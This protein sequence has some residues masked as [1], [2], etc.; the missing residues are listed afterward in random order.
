MTDI[1]ECTSGVHSCVAVEQ[2]C[3]NL[4]G[5][6]VCINAD[7]SFSAPG[8]TPLQGNSPGSLPSE[9]R[10]PGFEISNEIAQG[11]SPIISGSGAL[12][13]QGFPGTN[14]ELGVLGLSHSQGRCP[15]GY[16][17]NLERQACDGEL[18]LSMSLVSYM[19][20][21]NLCFLKCKSHSF[22]VHSSFCGD[23]N[24]E[25]TLVLNIYRC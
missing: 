24:S 8:P 12:G 22:Y 13:V 19:C 3:Y 2:V 15:P 11:H 4:V 14:T 7:G 10:P 9:L 23:V 25:I 16:S 1:N 6:Y 17:F 5:S 18:V 20:F 21:M